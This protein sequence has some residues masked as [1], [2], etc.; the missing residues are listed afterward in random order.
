MLAETQLSESVHLKKKRSLAKLRSVEWLGQMVAS[1]SWMTSMAFY[2]LS[3]FGD[4]LQLLAATAWTVANL[5]SLFEWEL[6][7]RSR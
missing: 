2:G 1:L 4:C 7:A 6:P 3:S 5:A